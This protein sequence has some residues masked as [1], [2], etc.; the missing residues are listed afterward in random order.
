MAQATAMARTPVGRKLLWWGVLGGG[1]AWAVQLTV[2]YGLE[3][4][5]CS[6][7]SRGKHILG[8]S[9]PS[10]IYILSAAAAVVTLSAIAIC[11]AAIRRGSGSDDHRDQRVVFMGITGLAANLLFLAIIVFGAIAPL[12]LSSCH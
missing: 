3:E 6:S 5:A 4:I 10:S 12:Y 1:I 11:I 7:G 9:V 8:M 2:G